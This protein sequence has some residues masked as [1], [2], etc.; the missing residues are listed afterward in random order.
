L[1][2]HDPYSA[3]KAGAEI[4]AASFRS[5]FFQESGVRVATARAGNVIGGGDWAADRLIPDAIRAFTSGQ[6]LILR[7]PGATRPWQH[8]LEPLAGY[9]LLAER[10]QESGESRFDC[11]W[12]FGPDSE[13]NSTVGHVAARV[14]ALW[15]GGKVEHLEKHSGPHE[16]GLLQLDS[17]R[18]K[19]LLGWKPAWQLEEALQHTVAW[20]RLCHAGGD[21]TALMREQIGAHF[22][23]P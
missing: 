13:G 23:H 22:A 9:L 7:N 12:N 15:G 18:A 2:G 16:A 4:V 21:V 8:V 1:G 11:A 20:Y 5:S 19:S 14:A 10:L 17:S 3:S 6:P